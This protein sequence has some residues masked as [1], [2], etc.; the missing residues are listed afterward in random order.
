MRRSGTDFDGPPV[1]GFQGFMPGRKLSFYPSTLAFF[2]AMQPNRGP[3][4]KVP[5]E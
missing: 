2:A 1:H 5:K 4:R 3:L